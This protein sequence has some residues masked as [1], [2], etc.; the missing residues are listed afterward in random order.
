MR[1]G[2][3]VIGALALAGAC[4]VTGGESATFSGGGTAG[5]ASSGGDQPG[6]DESTRGTGVGSGGGSGTAGP[7]G[8]TASAPTSGGVT[9]SGGA[10]TAAG[11]TGGQADATSTGGD[12][13]T[14]E[15]TEGTSTGSSGDASSSGD[16][17]TDTGDAS[18]S[19]SSDDGVVPG[20]DYEPCNPD[21]TCDQ[22]GEICLQVGLGGFCTETCVNDMA[23]PAA[24]PGGGLTAGCEFLLGFPDFSADY[25]GIIGCNFI[26]NDCPTGMTCTPVVMGLTVCEW[27]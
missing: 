27:V 10:T 7:D 19:G 8:T 13:G 4:T 25:C 22:A 11:S 14:G 16:P 26:I 6:D 12:T 9:D 24:P 23:C 3:T 1:R 5:P 18:S 2:A 20:E 21:G 15:S 17:G